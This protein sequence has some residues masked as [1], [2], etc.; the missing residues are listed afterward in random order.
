MTSAEFTPGKDRIFYTKAVYDQEEIDAVVQCLKDGWL[1]PGVLTD[2]FENKIAALFGKRYGL[3]V[4]S[5]CHGNCQS[6][7]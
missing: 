1:G 6:S 3:F 2:E 4:N 7:T 5:N